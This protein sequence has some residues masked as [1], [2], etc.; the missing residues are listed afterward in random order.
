[1]GI[2][3]VMGFH[4]TSKE[5]RKSDQEELTRGLWKRVHLL[6]AVPSLKPTV[7]TLC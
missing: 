3:D 5:K 7:A 2:D 1:M 4:N 6:W